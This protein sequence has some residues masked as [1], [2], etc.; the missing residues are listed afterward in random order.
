MCVGLSDC[1]GCDIAERQGCASGC[2]RE[3]ALILMIKGKKEGASTMSALG[4]IAGK[5]HYCFLHAI[6]P[7]IAGKK[8]R[9]TTMTA[10]GCRTV[11]SVTLRRL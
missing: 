10:V 1:R 3:A 6:I 4:M 11:E 9:A 2:D 8:E 5:K 7:M